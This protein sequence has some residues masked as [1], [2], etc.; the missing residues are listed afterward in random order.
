[1][2]RGSALEC[3]A[4]HYVLEVCRAISEDHNRHGKA[5][6][7]RIVAMLT[8][9]GQRGYCVREESRNYQAANFD[10]DSDPDTDPEIES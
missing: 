8:R 4:I 3:G 9:M 7:D 1:M 5:M 2:A 10:A 6:L